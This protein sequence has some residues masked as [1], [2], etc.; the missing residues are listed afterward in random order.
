M[1]TRH[2]LSNGLTVLIHEDRSAPV[3]AVLTHVKTGYFHEEDRLAGIS[4]LLEHMYFKGTPR[5]PGPEDIARATKAVG[6]VL[7]AFTYY[8]ETGYYSVVPAERLAD[9]LDIQAD[10]LA[11]TRIDADQLRRETEV[12]IQEGEQKKDAAW[13]YATES[14]YALAFDRHR[15]RRWRIGEPDVLR[16]WTRDDMLAYYRGTYHPENM[17]LVVSGNVDPECALPELER[18]YGRIA[19]GPRYVN[20]GP[21]EP[22]QTAPRYRRLRGDIR[23]RLVL[24]GFHTVPHFHADSY[25]LDV[26]ASLL[27]DGRASRLF[28]N[29]RERQGLA[30]AL[31]AWHQTFHDIGYF[32]LAAESLGDDLPETERALL[33]EVLR[34]RD[35]GPTATEMERIRTRIRARTVFDTEEPLG[36][37][38]RLATYEALGGYE[39]E[40][41]ELRHLL[42]VTPEDVRRVA[43]RYFTPGNTSLLEYVPESSGI[44]EGSPDSVPALFAPAPSAVSEAAESGAMPSTHSL[45]APSPERQEPEA[46]LEI[47]AGLLT[48]RRSGSAPVMAVELLFPG[49]RLDETDKNAGITNLMLRSMLKGNATRN[50][51]QI[52]RAFEGL[53]SSLEWIHGL[54][55]WGFGFHV[56]AERAGEALALAAD[57]ARHP[58]FL[59]ADVDRERE[60]LL[61]DI[62]RAQ[63]NASERAMDLMDLA[64][65]G[66]HPYAFPERGT[67]EAL[68]AL[69]PENLRAWHATRLR[70][71]L[72][73]G[74]AGAVD[75]D[76]LR[77]ALA[78]LFPE[79]PASPTLRSAPREWTGIV[80]R[81]EERDRN[82][83][84]AAL[85]FPT[86]DAE[87]PQRYAL[88]LI[89][90]ILSGLGGRLFAE[91]RGRQGL[92]YTVAAF[93]TC[94][95]EAGMFTVYTATAPDNEE[96]ARAAI[97][98]EMERLR[99]EL[100]T[101]DEIERAKAF[102]AGARA[103]AMQTSRAQSRDLSRAAL[104]GRP[105]EAGTLYLERIQSLTREDLQAAAQR[106]FRPDAYA[107]GVLRGG[108]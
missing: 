79:P 4:H 27:S 75:P 84:A 66:Q 14:L 60:T 81:V 45:A 104:Y 99:Q 53:G 42:S 29:V 77:E 50:G 59:Q 20:P 69:T 107:L 72:I 40:S 1:V 54:D 87:S 26:L 15:I 68:Q 10:A 103:I 56:L 100:V 9:A 43:A 5:R 7:N 30:T 22:V 41:E 57:V 19:G 80:E 106:Y 65:Y 55:F 102:L 74:A 6:G 91:V 94:R 48:V 88:D 62:R 49:G 92:A 38:R 32:V 97:L 61:A 51:E 28:Q 78:G 101:V 17:V 96:T 39:R 76:A 52:A 21:Q 58:D 16:S 95:R 24:L 11:N 3:A 98:V 13:A 71:P 37:A 18:L 86:V 63:D 23:Q 90:Q 83:T 33:A 108:K 64:A 2:T 34:L 67:S 46:R 85:G 70:A 82:Q 36:R 12:V 73:V 93:H 25:A 8:E 31:N 44:A 47:P 105:V 89:A 35:E